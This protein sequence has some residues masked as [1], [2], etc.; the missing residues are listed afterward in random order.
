MYLVNLAPL[1]ISVLPSRSIAL[2]CGVPVNCHANPPQRRNPSHE[3]TPQCVLSL[4]PAV[5]T[6]NANH[7]KNVWQRYRCSGLWLIKDDLTTL[8]L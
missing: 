8:A 7:T 5:K 1:E 4:A 3:V 2:L 6:S